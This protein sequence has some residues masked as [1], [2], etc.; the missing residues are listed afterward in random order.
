MAMI[1]VTTTAIIVMAA[2]FHAPIPAVAIVIL[3]PWIVYR[4]GCDADRS[5]RDH[6]RGRIDHLR[7][8]INHR[9]R[10]GLRVNNLRRGP[11]DHRRWPAYN[12]GIGR[13]RPDPDTHV[14][15]SLR[16]ERCSEQTKRKEN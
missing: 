11:D 4:A 9:G 13:R 5:G 15:S 14:N 12:Y 6:H 10:A 7:R 1:A 3:P 16:R 8:R 2:V